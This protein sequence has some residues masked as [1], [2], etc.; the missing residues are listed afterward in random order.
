MV[1]QLK[2]AEKNCRKALT[3]N[4]DLLWS[5]VKVLP[6]SGVEGVNH[7]SHAGGLSTAHVVKI[8]HTLKL[9]LKLRQNDKMATSSSILL[10]WIAFSWRPNTIEVVFFLRRAS[11]TF[12][13]EV[14]VDVLLSPLLPGALGVKV[15]QLWKLRVIFDIIFEILCASKCCDIANK[16]DNVAN[17][18]PRPD[19]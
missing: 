15:S 3:W 11:E 10:T 18:S 7:T 16:C 2:N 1:F 17:K 6:G 12:P 9:I 13:P 14:D 8:K 4:E 5:P 19:R